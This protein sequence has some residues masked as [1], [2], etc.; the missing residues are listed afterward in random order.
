M[1]TL[2]SE[3]RR[4]GHARMNAAAISGQHSVRRLGTADHVEQYN[5]FMSKPGRR[6]AR[7]CKYNVQLP[8]RKSPRFARLPVASGDSDAPAPG[9]V[10]CWMQ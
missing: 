9:R 6:T 3:E 5:V 1:R 8:W 4:Y 7:E 2:S 10:Y